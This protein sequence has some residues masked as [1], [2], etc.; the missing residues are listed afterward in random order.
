[1]QY[2]MQVWLVLPQTARVQPPT[3]AWMRVRLSPACYAI[4]PVSLH[5]V[6]YLCVQQVCPQ[7]PPATAM[8]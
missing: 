3:R 4:K 2:A 1:L 8:L 6:S 7:C 5:V